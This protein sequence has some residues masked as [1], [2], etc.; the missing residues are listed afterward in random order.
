MAQPK[1]LTQDFVSI[2][3]MLV[4]LP[5]DSIQGGHVLVYVAGEVSI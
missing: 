5:L 2:H 1:T 3:N 4:Y